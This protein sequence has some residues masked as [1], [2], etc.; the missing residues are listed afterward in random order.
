MYHYKETGSS[1]CDD[2]KLS[3]KFNNFFVQ[4][5]IKYLILILNAIIK[6]KEGLDLLVACYMS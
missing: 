3:L 1:R 6:Y 2:I 5:K 4:C